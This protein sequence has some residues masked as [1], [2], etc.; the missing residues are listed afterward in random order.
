MSDPKAKTKVVEAKE[1]DNPKR[2]LNL[3]ETVE[4]SIGTFE[5]KELTAYQMLDV[6]SEGLFL[7]DQLMTKED[8]EKGDLEVDLAM[9]AAVARQ[10]ETKKQLNKILATFCN[11]ED[12]D[13]FNALKIKDLKMLLE[14]IT[15]VTDFEEVKELFLSLT[16][17]LKK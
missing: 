10:P 12:E 17:Q 9:L 6:V 11:T 7:L 13:I 16:N 4:L 3:G 5:V 2:F 8:L 1:Q 14:A 15:K